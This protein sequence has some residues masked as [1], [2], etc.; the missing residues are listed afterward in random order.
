MMIVVYLFLW[1]EDIAAEHIA[2]FVSCYITKYLQV[3]RVVRYIE[4]SEK[5]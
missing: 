2:F 1:F 5:K 3:L 4:Y